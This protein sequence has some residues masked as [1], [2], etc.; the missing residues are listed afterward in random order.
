V[1]GKGPRRWEDVPYMWIGRISKTG[2]FTKRYLQIQCNPNKKI[3]A[4]FFSQKLN[5]PQNSCGTT[6]DPW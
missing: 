5:L 3:P 1:I 2:L 4:S 6:K